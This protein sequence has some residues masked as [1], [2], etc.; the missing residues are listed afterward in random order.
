MGIQIIGVLFVFSW[1]F[2]VMGFWFYLLNYLGWL[3]I[4]P[5]EEEV[6]MDISRHKGSAYDITGADEERV[7][8]LNN[9]RTLMEDRSLSRRGSSKPKKEDAAKGEHC[10]EE[11]DKVEVAEAEA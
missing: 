3:R 9:S 8:E 5:L 11:S 4:D 6:G 10:S 1:T 7:K 2:T